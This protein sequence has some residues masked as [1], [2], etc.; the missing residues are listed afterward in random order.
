MCQGSLKIIETLDWLAN[1][2]NYTATRGPPHAFPLFANATWTVRIGARTVPLS[3]AH[4]VKRT[5][6]SGP[7]RSLVPS[8]FEGYVSRESF[9]SMLRAILVVLTIGVGPWNRASAQ[10][11]SLFVT[12]V[13]VVDVIAGR[14]QPDMTVEIGG[15]TISALSAGRPVRIPR[16][17]TVV[18]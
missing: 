1:P 13:A 15:R 11:A 6:G 12:H 14:A 10:S 2:K 17:A 9:K 8:K 4:G 3:S 16:R 5:A 18:D 7:Q